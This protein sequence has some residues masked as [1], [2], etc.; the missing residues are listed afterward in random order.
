MLDSGCASDFRRYYNI[1]QYTI[2]NML[3]LLQY[4]RA[5]HCNIIEV[6]CLARERLQYIGNIRFP[7]PGLLDVRFCVS[8]RDI[9]FVQ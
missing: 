4:M 6:H 2:Y 8:S 9:C 7:K 3:Q 1:L 5:A